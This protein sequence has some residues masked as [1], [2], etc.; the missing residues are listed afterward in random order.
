MDAL[1]DN[2]ALRQRGVQSLNQHVKD[3]P[4]SSL[5][6]AVAAG[7]IVGGGFKN[8]VGLAVL[9]LVGRIAIQNFASNFLSA[10][11]AGSNR[12][13]AANGAGAAHASSSNEG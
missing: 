11:M 10:V 5:A 12:D 6:I 4:L 2:A 1:D 9:G 8:R 13:R 7:F 3:A